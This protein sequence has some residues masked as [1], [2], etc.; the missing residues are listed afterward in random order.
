M[1]QV[2]VTG[3]D[4]GAGK[5]QVVAALARLLA[6]DGA[7]VQI[8]KVVE[9]GRAA[10]A[11]EK[12]DAERARHLSRADVA[13]F[14]LATF[15]APLAPPVAAALVGKEIIFDDLL[16][17]LNSLADCD[18]RIL[19]GAGGIATPLDV[20]GR[21]WADFASAVNVDAMIVV[22]PDR[23][24][25]INQARLAYA[26]AKQTGVHV[27]VW[28]NAVTPIDSAVAASNRSSLSSLGVPLW[29]EQAHDAV[30]PL[31]A[32]A[33]RRQLAVERVDPNALGSG[34]AQTS[35]LGSM[36]ST[37]PSGDLA[38]H[39]REF[40]E[41]RESKGLRRVLRVTETAP[42][43]LNL[44]DNDY[45]A[46]A[47]DPAVAKAVAAAVHEYGSSA[48]AS[49]LV[50]GWHKPHARLVER[51]GAWHGFP[52]GLL[53]NSGYAAN[54]AVLGVL[55][56]KGD[57][58]LADRLIHHSM[59]AGLLRSGARLRRYEHLNL[60][61]LEAMLA[62]A[63]K[64]ARAIF[65]VTESVFSMDGDFPDLT[66]MADIKRRHG[67][68]WIVD[69]AHGLGWYGPEGAGLVRESGV[70]KDVDVLVGTLGKTLASGGAYTLFRH[71][72]V[73]D[74]VVNTAGEFIYSTSLSPLNVAA[75]DAALSRVHELAPQQKEWQAA[76]QNFRETLRRD[77]WV[78]PKGNSPIVP[79]RLDDAEAAVSLADTLREA[80][81]FAAA[82]RPPTVPAGTSRLRF[83]LK[84]TFGAAEGQRVLNVMN[85]WRAAR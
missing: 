59:I 32:A 30:A 8:V 23:L 18:W 7:H 72:A 67:F 76:S 25:A 2:L 51:L 64:S 53:W 56:T 42:D 27:G 50:T 68:C 55:P 77:G 21:D 12:G 28:L 65:V 81:V 82:I 16:A 6:T 3:S 54:S 22:V 11:V 83:S 63:Q 40:L 17:R 69:E 61:Q 85:R 62:A 44:A 43:T 66:R 70:E 71:E 45:L 33:V 79:V 35:A 47:R 34:G 9:T 4:T 78:V 31:D 24:G 20:A 1:R 13:A 38:A 57:L 74:Y 36:R 39:V 14:T 52:G 73:R 84:R 75:A 41:D 60:D 48:S 26:R 19:E 46:L 37:L 10:D 58:V 49:P 15:P 5:T 80:G 29:A